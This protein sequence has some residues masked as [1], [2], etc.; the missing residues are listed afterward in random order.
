MSDADVPC[1]QLLLAWSSSNL[2]GASGMGP[3]AVSKG[4]GLKEDHHGGLGVVGRYVSKDAMEAIAGGVAAPVCLEFRPGE[5]ANLLLAKVYAASAQRAGQYQ[6][7]ALKDPSRRLAPWDLWGAAEQQVLATK[8]VAPKNGALTPIA[9]RVTPAD[10]VTVHEYTTHLVGAA[11]DCLFAGRPFVISASDSARG[12][13]LLREILA[14]L[15][16]HLVRS[17]P[18]ST[19]AMSPEAFPLGGAVVVPGVSDPFPEACVVADHDAGTVNTA[20]TLATR[21]ASELLS[22][23]GLRTSATEWEEVRAWAMMQE[24]GLE[25]LA[26]AEAARLLSGSLGPAFWDSVTKHP[27]RVDLLAGWWQDGSFATAW[28]PLLPAQAEKGP[29]FVAELIA[30]RDHW[31]AEFSDGLQ[32]WLLSAIDAGPSPRSVLIALEASQTPPKI[33]SVRLAKALSETD[34][35]LARFDFRVTTPG[36]T[37]LTAHQ[38]RE[39]FTRGRPPAQHLWTVA[40]ANEDRLATLTAEVIHQFGEE[41]LTL[42]VQKWPEPTASDLLQVLLRPG[43]LTPNALRSVLDRLPEEK[44]TSAVRLNWPQI[45]DTFGVPIRVADLLQVKDS[46]WWHFWKARRDVG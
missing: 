3:V 32:T 1:E 20:G 21:A 17:T 24:R 28:E 9:V 25:S 39:A 11:L 41:P 36:W 23:D 44:L 13:Q 19:L 6:V 4:F 37:R 22:N 33:H 45:A 27:E 10:P 43:L 46:K 34:A 16:P 38:L 29:D 35:P 40:M 12:V 26:A 14:A 2:F 5:E 15:P 31:P 42:A 30:G 7:H 8:E 18:V